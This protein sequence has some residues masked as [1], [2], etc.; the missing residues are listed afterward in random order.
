MSYILTPTTEKIILPQRGYFKKGDEGTAIEIIASFLAFNFMG[1]E[2][3][4]NVK[5][6]DMLGN[7]FGVNL[8]AWIKEFQRQNDLEDDGCIGIITLGKLREY[9]MDA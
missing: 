4:L 5:I 8:E 7:Y 9:G 1:Y 2:Y 3:K 6:D